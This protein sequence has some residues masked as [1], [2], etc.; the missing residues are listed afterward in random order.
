MG[1]LCLI[2]DITILLLIGEGFVDS[3]VLAKP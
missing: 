2:F 3:L 1:T